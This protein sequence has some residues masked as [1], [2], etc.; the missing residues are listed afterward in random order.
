MN[1][2]GEHEPFPMFPKEHITVAGVPALVEAS[3][4]ANK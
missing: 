2:N 3:Q 1:V 4:G